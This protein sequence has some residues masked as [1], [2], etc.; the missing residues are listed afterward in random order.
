[1][2]DPN[3][4]KVVCGRQMQA[5]YFSRSPIPYFREQHEAPVFHH[6]GL[7]GFRRDF[8]M[9]YCSLPQTPLEK[10][11]QLEQLRVL[12]NGYRIDVALTDSPTL[13]INTPEDLVVANSAGNL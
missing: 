9:T 8:L 11:E 13:E 6:L 4:V 7:Y 5:L 2:S 12:E 3:K 10:C 1:M